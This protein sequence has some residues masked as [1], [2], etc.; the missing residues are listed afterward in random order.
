[1]KDKANLFQG[2]RRISIVTFTMVLFGAFG[3]GA[4]QFYDRLRYEQELVREQFEQSISSLE[5]IVASC[6]QYI[7]SMQLLSQEYYAT[8]DKQ[9][10]H[11]LFEHLEYDSNLGYSHL[12]EVP[13]R[14]EK[15]LYGNLTGDIDIN[16]IS[17]DKIKEINMALRLNSV[18]RAARK[19]IPNTAWAYYTSDNFINIYPWV[20]SPDFRFSQELLT[21]EFYTDANIDKN[22][23]KSFFWTSAYKDEAGSGW[24]VTCAAPIYEKEKFKGSVAIDITLEEL[25]NI[26]SKSQ[27]E[28]G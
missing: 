16:T 23:D 22:P 10:S 4:L 3:L 9:G 26:I 18:F 14:F 8:S 20:S 21:H 13:S 19:S 25:S 11:Y 7:K 6:T 27:L 12:N 17:E 24:M 2:Y 28:I 1:M 15:D 5:L